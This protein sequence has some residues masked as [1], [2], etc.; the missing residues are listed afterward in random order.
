MPLAGVD[1]PHIKLPH[2]AQLLRIRRN[3]LLL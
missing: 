2:A 3:E 1:A